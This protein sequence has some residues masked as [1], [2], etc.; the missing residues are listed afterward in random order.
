GPG[1]AVVVIGLHERG[2][3]AA[4]RL[5]VVNVVAQALEADEVLHRLPDDA[6]HRHSA[7]HA[8]QDDLFLGK[9][10]HA[11]QPLS[12]RPSFGSTVARRAREGPQG[13][14]PNPSLA[15]RAK[16]ARARTTISL[17]KPELTQQ[18][19]QYHITFETIPSQ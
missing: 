17:P 6:G 1:G 3:G 8:E 13:R 2:R 4:V 7:H 14:R 15:R 12:Q 16:V 11:T 10:I 9:D 19:F 5:D 18:T